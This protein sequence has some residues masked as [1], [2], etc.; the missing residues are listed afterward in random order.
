VSFD[1]QG[2]V[3]GC[4]INGLVMLSMGCNERYVRSKHY[5]SIFG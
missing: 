4:C 3:K 1:D 5:E 2:Q